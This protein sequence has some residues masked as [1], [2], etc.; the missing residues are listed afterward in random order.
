MPNW[1]TKHLLE[2]DLPIDRNLIF[3]KWVTQKKNRN[4]IIR[5]SPTIIS[6]HFTIKFPDISISQHSMLSHGK[7]VIPKNGIRNF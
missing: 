5:L 3:K 1:N 6:C 4:T 2:S 7:R